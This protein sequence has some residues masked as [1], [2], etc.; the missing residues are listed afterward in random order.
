[1]FI[2]SDSLDDVFTDLEN[3]VQEEMVYIEFLGIIR[4]MI[5]IYRFFRRGFHRFR[6]SCT[7]GGSSKCRRPGTYQVFRVGQLC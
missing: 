2:F 3:R 1:M 5:F 7:G 4:F 6:E